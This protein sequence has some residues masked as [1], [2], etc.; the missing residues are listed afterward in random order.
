MF[1]IVV[2]LCV[3]L[4][5]TSLFS[6]KTSI[7]T[8]HLPNKNSWLQAQQLRFPLV[9]TKRTSIDELINH[10]LKVRFLGANF[11]HLPIDSAI[12]KWSGESITHLDFEVSY[13]KNNLISINIRAESCGAYCTS[14]NEYF[15]YSVNTGKYLN[16]DD[17]IDTSG[18]FREMV[19]TD[20]A[21]IF[22]HQKIEFKQKNKDLDKD[23]YNWVLENYT[24]CEEAFIINSFALK[25]CYLQ[26]IYN[27][28]F[29]RM[30]NHFSPHIVL[31]YKYEDI[32]TFLQL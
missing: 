11:S 14:W 13:N 26:I 25:E 23:T 5:S 1:R 10:D 8:L 30:L 24:I 4:F 32:D 2:I 27:C 28:S 15:T 31:K 19:L 9:N 22:E 29:P 21:Y 6:Q 12:L 16:I 20:K 17:I 7:D 3:L 18:S